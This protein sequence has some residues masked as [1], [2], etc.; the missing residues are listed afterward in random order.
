[1][2]S[3]S[4]F[5]PFI[6]GKSFPGHLFNP[7]HFS[8][9]GRKEAISRGRFLWKRDSIPPVLIDYPGSLPANPSCPFASWEKHFIVLTG[10]GHV[11]KII[12]SAWLN[13][14]EI[15][16]TLEL[17]HVPRF[18]VAR[19]RSFVI[20]DHG[21]RQWA[22]AGAKWSCW[23]N[24]ETEPKTNVKKR[25]LLEGKEGTILLN[26]FRLLHNNVFEVS[27]TVGTITKHGVSADEMPGGWVNICSNEGLAKRENLLS[28]NY[29]KSLM[30]C[31]SILW[32]KR[33]FSVIE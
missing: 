26:W 33:W 19:F 23:L 12:G 21:S 15:I 7:K 28:F 2:I 18:H 32:G 11:L 4:K 30:D 17:C 1:M 10:E 14:W 3:V 31:L 8:K 13:C 27:Y 6:P 5:W 22:N 20:W 24:W 16:C 9:A 29:C 25:D